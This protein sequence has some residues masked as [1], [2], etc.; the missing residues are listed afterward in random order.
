MVVMVIRH[1]IGTRVLD[2]RTDL[3]VFEP[4]VFAELRK[5]AA[6]ISCEEFAKRAEWLAPDLGNRSLADLLGAVQ[7]QE[8]FSST[9][10]RVAFASDG[11]GANLLGRV[12]PGKELPALSED[13]SISFVTGDW[14]VGWN[15]EAQQ[16]NMTTTDGSGVRVCTPLMSADVV[17]GFFQ[18]STGTLEPDVVVD[19][20]DYPLAAGVIAASKGES[21]ADL[22]SFRAAAAIDAGATAGIPLPASAS[23]PSAAESRRVARLVLGQIESWLQVESFTTQQLSEVDSPGRLAHLLKRLG[24]RHSYPS[25][26]GAFQSPTFP[27][28]HRPPPGPRQPVPEP[29][30]SHPAAEPGRAQRLDARGAPEAPRWAALRRR[31]ADE[32]E[33]DRFQEDALTWAVPDNAQQ[34]AVIGSHERTRAGAIERWLKKAGPAADPALLAGAGGLSAGDLLS[35]CLDCV[36]AA[37]S[38]AASA[39]A[40]AASPA[41]ERRVRVTVRSDH[42]GETVSEM[43][44]QERSAVQADISALESDAAACAKLHAWAQLAAADSEHA[45]DRLR[46][47]VEVEP[48]GALQRLIS[49]SVQINSVTVDAEPEHVQQL[50]AVPGVLDMSLLRAVF[51]PRAASLGDIVLRAVRAVRTHKFGR[52]RL[53]HLLERQDSGTEADP[54]AAFS[55]IS[56]EEAQ[57]LLAEALQRFQAAWAF[58]DPAHT[59]QVIQFVTALQQQL[60]GAIEKGVSWPSLSRF[61]ASVMRRVDRRAGSVIGGTMVL[62][63]PPQAAWCQDAALQWVVDLNE[64]KSVASA[65]RELRSELDGVT[66]QLKKA[67]EESAKALQAASARAALSSGQRQTGEKL[68]KTAKKKAAAEKRKAESEAKEVKGQQL[69]PPPPKKKKLQEM[70]KELREELGDKDGRPPCWFFHRGDDG[71]RFP[72]GQCRMGHH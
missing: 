30:A 64:A 36:Q 25:S 14:V 56:Q 60:F 3:A 17:R 69:Q 53:P 10:P 46:Q 67:R 9:C 8:L 23:S 28:V 34:R 31:A 49:G 42:G 71:C 29:P 26:A 55:K 47:E 51:G 66:E 48:A 38:N 61:Y 59:G 32:E 72:A 35:L 62:H 11:Q 18:S 54:L 45:R 24:E 19:A 68:S 43:E 44:Q 16:Y 37:S 7:W 2:N 58:S 65:K 39:S 40:I 63:D 21:E 4:A 52:V 50:S 13:G 57:R 70:A 33:W 6:A 22:A 27:F 15:A 1:G 41:T 20:S 12:V 5:E